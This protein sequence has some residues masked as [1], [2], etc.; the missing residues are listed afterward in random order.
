MAS[1]IHDSATDRVGAKVF[2]SPRTARLSHICQLVEWLSRLC[3][4]YPVSEQHQR[5]HLRRPGR[6]LVVSN[7][8]DLRQA[9]I[10][11]TRNMSAEGLEVNRYGNQRV[12]NQLSTGAG[13]ALPVDDYELH[14]PIGNCHHAIFCL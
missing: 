11:L 6:D 13:Y 10:S 3:R 9:S 5:P 12:N 14:T 1:Q 4:G 7:S 8:D 2:Q